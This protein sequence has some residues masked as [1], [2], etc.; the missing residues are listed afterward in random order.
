M[1]INLAIKCKNNFRHNGDMLCVEGDLRN[2]WYIKI[3]FCNFVLI[4]ILI[5]QLTNLKCILRTQTVVQTESDTK[6]IVNNKYF[7]KSGTANDVGGIISANNKKNTVN[8]T[9]IEMHNVT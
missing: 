4:E 9:R 2:V 1:H 7:P 8:D 5:N 3:R 6:I